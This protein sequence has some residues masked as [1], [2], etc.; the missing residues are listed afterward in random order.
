MRDERLFPLFEP[1]DSLSGVGPK[2]KPALERLAG[3]EHVWDLLLHLPER[4][5][6]RRVRPSIE[7][8]EFGE[9]ATVKGEVHAYHPP[10]NEKSPHR[11]LEGVALRGRRGK[12]RLEAA[13]ART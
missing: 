2:L 11:V 8:T 6:D 13:P 12:G 5:V 3:G 7:A 10:Y 4:W 9:V 1:L